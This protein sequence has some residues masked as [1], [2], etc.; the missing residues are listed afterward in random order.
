MLIGYFDHG[1]RADTGKNIFVHRDGW[2]DVGEE[3]RSEDG[4]L[5]NKGAIYYP[6]GTSKSYDR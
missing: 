3:T 4:Q 2:V 5:R 6:D 1:R